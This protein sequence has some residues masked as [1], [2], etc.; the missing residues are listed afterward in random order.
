MRID[1]ALSAQ[2]RADAREALSLLDGAAT[3]TDAARA[4]L[5]GKRSLERRSVAWAVNAFVRA[6]LND[7][8]RQATIDWYDERLR[9]VADQFGERIIDEITRADFRGWMERSPWAASS[10]AGTARAAR[11]LWRWAIQHEPPLAVHDVTTGLRFSVRAKTPDGSTKVLSVPHCAAI[12]NRVPAGHRSA[13]ALMLFAGLRPEEVAGES[14]KPWL[15]WQCVNIAEKI[16]RVP[17]ECSKT[18][19]S[20]TLEGLPDALWSWLTPRDPE[21]TVATAQRRTLIEHVKRAGGFSAT[22]PWPQ[23]G[24]RHSFGTYALAATNDPGKVALWMG[25]NGNPTMLH[26]HYRGMASKAEAE[27]FWA[28]RPS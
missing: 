14:G 9:Y 18:R 23:D 3:L 28:L 16:V 24:L 5:G 2:Q 20:R 11:A 10:K 21:Q 26:R 1:Y 27:K 22:V 13:V 25:H 7:G 12:L 4:Y 15:R 6:K 8:L 19:Q 17:A